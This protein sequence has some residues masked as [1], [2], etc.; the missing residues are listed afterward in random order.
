[1]VVYASM[2][3]IPFF[4]VGE[5]LTRFTSLSGLV[6]MN[7]NL[8]NVKVD[9]VVKIPISSVAGFIRTSTCH[10]YC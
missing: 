2:A 8:T 5:V 7:I 10:M 3:I 4:L 9:G 1:M 6:T